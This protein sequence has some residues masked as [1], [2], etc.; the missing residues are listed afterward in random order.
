[1]PKDAGSDVVSETQ[2]SQQILFKTL[3]DI[4]SLGRESL[5][6]AGAVYKTAAGALSG[7]PWGAIQATA[8]A[9]VNVTS[10]NWTNSDASTA[11]DVPAGTTIYGN[12]TAI[13]LTSGKIIAYKQ[14]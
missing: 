5:G 6:K 10:G 4:E 11:V 14:A 1:M 3:P 13:S 12:F 2:D 9:V 8:A 7:G